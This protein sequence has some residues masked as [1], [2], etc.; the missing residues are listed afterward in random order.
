MPNGNIDATGRIAKLVSEIKDERFESQLKMMMM[1]STTTKK[2]KK[3]TGTADDSNS[4][5]SLSLTKV[6]SVE[7]GKDVTLEW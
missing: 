7:P 3:S 6:I 4:S 2:T 1:M 5:S